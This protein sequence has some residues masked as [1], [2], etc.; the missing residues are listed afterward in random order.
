MIGYSLGSV[1]VYIFLSVNFYGAFKLTSKLVNENWSSLFSLISF[2]SLYYFLVDSRLS[3]Y[4][5]KG[6][7]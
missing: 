4:E 6:Y 1:L 7:L 3:S 2:Q 5:F